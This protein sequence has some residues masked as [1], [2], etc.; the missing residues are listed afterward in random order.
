MMRWDREAMTRE[1]VEKL[2]ECPDCY[3]LG[4]L[5]TPSKSEFHGKK[6]CR[7]CGGTGYVESPSAEQD[8]A[9][10]AARKAETR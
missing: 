5:R 4:F 2:R 9:N 10:D 6:Q 8:G 7:K 1:D 3:G